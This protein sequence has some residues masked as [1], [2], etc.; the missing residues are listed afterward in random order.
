[1][2]GKKLL[3]IVLYTLVIV[4]LLSVSIFS[5]YAAQSAVNLGTA[6]NFVILSKTGVSTTGTTAITGDIGVSPIDG[7]A[8]TG[9]GLIM[10][11]TNE[12]STSSLVTGK[13]YA[14]DYTPPT[15]AKMTTAVSDMETAYTDAAGRTETSIVTELGAGDISGMTI[16]PGLYKWGTGVLISTDI[17][18]EGDSNAIWI[19]QISGD[20]TVASGAKIILKGGAQAKNIFW[21]VGGGVGVEIGTTAH[22]EGNIIAQK[23]I[24]LRTGATLNGRALSQTAVTLDANEI[25][26]SASSTAT[27]TSTSGTTGTSSNNNQANTNSNSGTSSGTSSVCRAAFEC[28][29]WSTCNAEKKQTRICVDKNNCGSKDNT[30][31]RTCTYILKSENNSDKEYLTDE[32]NK[33][34]EGIGQELNNQISERKEEIKSGEYTSPMGQMM[35]VRELSKN[36]KELRVNNINAQTSLSIIAETD[37]DGKTRFKT[38]LTNGTEIEIKIMPNMASQKALEQLMVKVCSSDNNC[39]IQLK[40]VGNGA[41]EKIQYEIQLERHSKL[42]GMFSKKMHVSAN[43]DAQTGAATM[44]KPWWSFMASEKLE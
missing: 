44:H 13:L 28:N 2:K 40:K 19:F 42:L 39:T 5:A 35:G 20:L 12:F 41:S 37:K 27:E 16:A 10:D 43:V 17:T 24:H 14:A 8:I 34:S 29:D 3:N 32:K 23:A 36:L 38:K 21:Q 25:S 6:G 15:P 11:A 26:L 22:I 31:T 1:M 30:E 18:L 4:S 7:T 9:F 33:S